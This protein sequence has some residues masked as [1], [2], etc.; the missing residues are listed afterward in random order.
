MTD[1]TAEAQRLITIDER[2]MVHILRVALGENVG[3][4][5]TDSLCLGIEST[6]INLLRAMPVNTEQ[7]GTDNGSKPCD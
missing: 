6:I 4:K 3:N 1:V 5:L 7:H 2:D